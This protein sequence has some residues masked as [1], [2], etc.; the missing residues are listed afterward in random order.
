LAPG[1]LLYCIAGQQAAGG[2][3]GDDADDASSNLTGYIGAIISIAA[4]VV[5]SVYAKKIIDKEMLKMNPKI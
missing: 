4:V 2:A 1:I 5:T 3:S